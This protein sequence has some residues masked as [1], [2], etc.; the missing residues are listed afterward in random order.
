[1]DLQRLTRAQR[2]SLIPW[3]PGQEI[4]ALSTEDAAMLR[5]AQEIAGV[6]SDAGLYSLAAPF[7]SLDVPAVSGLDPCISPP[8]AYWTATAGQPPGPVPTDPAKLYRE[9]R[10]NV[11]AHAPASDRSFYRTYGELQAIAERPLRCLAAGSPDV[12]LRSRLQLWSAVAA[13]LCAD[14]E[15][16][17]ADT[18]LAL[19][20]ADL[21]GIQSYLFGTTDVGVGGV[22]RSLRARSFYLS[23]IMELLAWSLLDRLHLSP[24]NLL[25]HAAGKFYILFSPVPEAVDVVETARAEVARWCLDTLHGELAITL[26]WTQFPAKALATAEMAAVWQQSYRVL[27]LEKNRRLAGALCGDGT[28]DS[29]AFLRPQAFGGVRP[30]EA[31]GRFPCEKEDR[32]RFCNR[33]V[34]VGKRLPRALWLAYD[35]GEPDDDRYPIGAF[36]WRLEVGLD[37]RTPD[38]AEWVTHLGESARGGALA[39]TCR[40]ARYV[41]VSDHGAPKT[42]EEIGKSAAGRPYLAC[43]K[44]DVDRL[45][46]RFVFGFDREEDTSSDILPLIAHLSESIDAFFSGH[47]EDLLKQEFRNCYTVFAGGD[48][49]T[50][51]GPHNEILRLARALSRDFHRYLGYSPGVPDERDVLTLSAGIA[52]APLWTPV[53]I[54]AHQAEAALKRAKRDGR[55]AVHIFDEPLAWDAFDRLLDRIWDQ[56]GKVRPGLGAQL[57]EQAPS[58]FLYRLHKYAAMWR[59]Y[60]HDGDTGQLRYQPLLAY[61]IGRNIDERRTPELRA[62]SK[63]LACIPLSGNETWKTEMDTLGLLVRLVLL[64][65]EG[66]G[67]RG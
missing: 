33:D 8:I 10:A 35:R 18:G 17:E 67:Q 42:F 3:L 43:L 52:V 23:Q 55:N 25:V 41:P 7:S 47:V 24:A 38:A 11:A 50:L 60:R 6:R 21:S 46:E 5:R 49:L 19:V 4:A 64:H 54:L 45:G 32:C 9:W 22:A 44:A 27:A 26:A 12:P 63:L 53:A 59:R 61:D 62:W 39:P 15:Q 57:L 56:D 1:M 37:G 31:C 51:I 34:L 16:G 20:C 40:L 28:W 58:G 13:C 30:C 66:G 36:G 14:P 48:D 2:L 65:R 29:G